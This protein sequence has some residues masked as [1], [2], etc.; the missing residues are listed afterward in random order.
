MLMEYPTVEKII[1]LKALVLAVIRV[2]KADRPAVLSRVKIEETIEACKE[3]EGDVYDKA[4]VLLH[5]LVK[6][7]PFASGN[8]RT[9]FIATK[10]FLYH[11]NAVFHVSDDPA[12]AKVMTGIREDFYTREEIREWIKHGKIRPFRR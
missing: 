8:R 10:D 2:K 11:N 5:S 1:E 6:K 9:A 12:Q 3:T 4:T 7:H